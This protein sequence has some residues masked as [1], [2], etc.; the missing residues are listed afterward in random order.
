[1]HRVGRT[2]RAEATGNARTLAA[3]EELRTLRAL[4]KAMGLPL[5][6]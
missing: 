3:P 4:E 1:M 6:Q 2:G 5:Q